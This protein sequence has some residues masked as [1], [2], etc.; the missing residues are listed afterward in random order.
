MRLDIGSG[1]LQCSLN[2]G[3]N[4]PSQYF[5]DN[6][7]IVYV[8]FFSSMKYY[9]GFFFFFNWLEILLH[10]GAELNLCLGQCPL[11]KKKK[12]FNYFILC[13]II[14]TIKDLATKI[15][16]GTQIFELV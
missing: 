8:L 3:Y 9:L 13:I 2:T 10:T 16:I 4:W 1:L 12:K 7:D 5:L 11:Y 15:G 6:K 14:E